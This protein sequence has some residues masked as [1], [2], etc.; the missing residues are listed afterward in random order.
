MGF[1][2]DIVLKECLTTVKQVF[3]HYQ[4]GSLVDHQAYKP[5]GTPSL[6]T[7][8][9]PPSCHI[10]RQPS[11]YIYIKRDHLL[12]PKW[13]WKQYGVFICFYLLFSAYNFFCNEEICTG[14]SLHI[15]KSNFTLK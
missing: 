7:G 8:T 3:I 10:P 5:C 13:V 9:R 1:Y 11:I 14:S 15:V 4:E 2:V 6:T 12:T